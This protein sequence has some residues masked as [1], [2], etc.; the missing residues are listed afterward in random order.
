MTANLPTHAHDHA[1][2]PGP[3]PVTETAVDPA[4]AACACHLYDAECA[5]H[6]AH[7]SG[8]GTWIDAA[9]DKLRAAFAAYLDAVENTTGG[10]A[11]TPL[12]R[13]HLPR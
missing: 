3:E 6:D 8:V 4:V 10:R 5:L 11:R 13:P 2:E 12:R 7:Q 1:A 9:G